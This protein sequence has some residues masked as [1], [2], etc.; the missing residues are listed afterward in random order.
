M[1]LLLLAYKMEKHVTLR[2]QSKNWTR[3]EM[4]DV[5]QREPPTQ[6]FH[7]TK[8]PIDVIKYTVIFKTG[9]SEFTV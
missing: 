9:L 6:P 8:H 7:S 1:L 3:Y 2:R 4:T 5:Y